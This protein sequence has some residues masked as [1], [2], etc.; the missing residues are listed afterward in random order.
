M[1]KE[2]ILPQ[3]L[4]F[5]V[6]EAKEPPMLAA[7]LRVK[8]SEAKGVLVHDIQV[9]SHNNKTWAIVIYQGEPNAFL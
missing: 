1:L 4:R 9:I 6:L 2:G 5:E 3:Q 8:L 7:Q